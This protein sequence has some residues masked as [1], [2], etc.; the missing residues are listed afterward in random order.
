MFNFKKT[1]NT[2]DKG[3]LPSPIEAVRIITQKCEKKYRYKL[4]F[5][6][7]DQFGLFSLDE[8]DCCEVIEYDSFGVLIA[9][10][11]ARAYAIQH[12]YDVSR[13]FYV[14]D[15]DENGKP[16]KPEIKCKYYGKTI[17]EDS[18]FCRHCGME[19]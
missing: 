14:C 16:I 12:G 11:V 2:T 4:L 10:F 13:A 1:E 7:K 6:K 17:E 19:Q 8:K 5:N 15:L 9:E 3:V 18:K